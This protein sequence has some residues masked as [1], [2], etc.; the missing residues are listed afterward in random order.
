LVCCATC[1]SHVFNIQPLIQ[2]LIAVDG[3]ANVNLCCE[4]YTAASS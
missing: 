2:S 3:D 4:Q 1:R